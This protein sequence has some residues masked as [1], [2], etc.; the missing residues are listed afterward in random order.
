MSF[1]VYKIVNRKNGH[2]YIGMT[3]RN[4]NVR[5]AIHVR[6]AFEARLNRP[7]RMIFHEALR[8]YGINEF[9]IFH[10][11]DAKTKKKALEIEK[12]IILK[13]RERGYTLYNNINHGGMLGLKHS[14]ETKLKMAKAKLGKKRS[15]QACEAVSKG[16]LGKAQPNISKGVKLWWERRKLGY[17]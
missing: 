7:R 4:I 8:K 2:I 3:G 14:R 1:K 15:K 12:N 11:K 16:M 13:Y 5:L 17:N 9:K 6:T 10:L